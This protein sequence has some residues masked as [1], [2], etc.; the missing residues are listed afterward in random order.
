MHIVR[1]QPIICIIQLQYT[2][3]EEKTHT[4]E[5]ICRLI[6]HEAH[7]CLKIANFGRAFDVGV[8]LRASCC[9]ISK[10]LDLTIPRSKEA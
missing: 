2:L 5:G 1:H 3:E 6:V 4:K 10:C 9:C 7:C 8:V